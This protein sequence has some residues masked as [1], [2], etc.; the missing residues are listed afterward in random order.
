MPFPIE[1]TPTPSTTT[2][3]FV[4]RDTTTNYLY[5]CIGSTPLSSSQNI[6]S[7]SQ[8]PSNTRCARLL[9]DAS[10][11]I[12]SACPSQGNIYPEKSYVTYNPS[13]KILTIN[14]ATV[15]NNATCSYTNAVKTVKIPT[16]A[17]IFDYGKF[18]MNFFYTVCGG[19][20]RVRIYRRGTTDTVTLQGVNTGNLCSNFWSPLR[21]YDGDGGGRLADDGIFI[22][23]ME[24]FTR[25]GRT[26]LR[27]GL[28]MVTWHDYNGN[29]PLAVHFSFS[30]GLPERNIGFVNNH[31]QM[32]YVPLNSGVFSSDFD[33]VPV[34]DPNSRYLRTPYNSSK[35]FVI[36]PYPPGVVARAWC[37]ITATI[38]VNRTHLR[39]LTGDQQFP[40]ATFSIPVFA[41]WFN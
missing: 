30:C 40:Q 36:V 35:L 20:E 19:Y 39:F 41:A 5:L 32:T 29:I 27:P 14:E 16:A 22:P 13:T 34:H 23:R 21:D 24:V 9:D 4:F 31:H 26:E 25:W 1:P 11:G 10:T 2:N 28:L 6:T 7:R 33:V 12:N 37:T 18:S 17:D 38:G 8:L 15:T 3:L